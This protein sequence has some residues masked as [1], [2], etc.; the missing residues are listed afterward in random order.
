[1]VGRSAVGR[2]GVSERGGEA[3]RG[4]AWSE[5]GGRGRDRGRA[6]GGRETKAGR[7]SA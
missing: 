5:D 1:M 7:E 6:A 2:E 3:G 4:R